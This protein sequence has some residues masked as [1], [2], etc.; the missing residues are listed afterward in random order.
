MAGAI[1]HVVLLMMENRSLDHMLGAFSGIDSD[2]DGVDPANPPVNA[3]DGKTYQHAATTTKQ[4]R[5]DPEARARR[6]H[7]TAY[8]RLQRIRRRFR[9]DPDRHPQ[10]LAR[11][12]EASRRSLVRYSEPGA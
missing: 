2:L 3:A 8:E 5:L 7:G 11:S 1:R 9:Q 12:E 10:A 4:V 6:R